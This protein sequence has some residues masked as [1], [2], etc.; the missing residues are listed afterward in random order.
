IC[1]GDLTQGRSG[2]KLFMTL[3]GS[4]LTEPI[5]PAGGPKPGQTGLYA[6]DRLA[7]FDINS[8]VL[9]VVGNIQATIPGSAKTQM[10]GVY[11][12]TNTPSKLFGWCYFLDA[13]ATPD[14]VEW[15]VALNIS[16]KLATASV[17]HLNAH[18]PL[19]GFLYGTTKGHNAQM[20]INNFQAL[21]KINGQQAQSILK[22]C[23]SPGQRSILTNRKHE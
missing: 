11:A 14:P 19:I 18:D 9:S 17:V 4:H 1:T 12:L 22:A 21:K 23:K 8:H 6:P 16:P 15:D 7:E 20:V 5:Q 3:A 13:T 2:T 10:V